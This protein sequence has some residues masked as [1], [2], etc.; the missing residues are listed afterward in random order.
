MKLIYKA[1]NLGMALSE[2]QIT[3][4]SVE[5]PKAYSSILCDIWN[6]TQGGE[7]GFI[8]SKEGELRNIAKEVDCIFNP[9][10]LDFNGKRVINRLYQELQEQANTALMNES[11]S[12]NGSIVA[13]LDELS[14][15]VPYALEY[16]LD[17]DIVGLMKLYNVKMEC[18]GECLLE[19]IV[20][21]LRVMSHVCGMKN[22]VFVGLKQCLTVEELKQLYE[23]VFCEKIN[24]I[25]IEYIHS[26]PISGEKGWILDRDLCIID[27]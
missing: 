14:R 16:D 27:L 20:E 15:Q 22:Y 4:L 8:L 10:A 18:F 9:F 23:F 26:A 2:N 25:I 7:G 24:L 19:K 21:Y 11:I 17:F 5:N 13:Y 3:V 12:L 1:Y 6:Q